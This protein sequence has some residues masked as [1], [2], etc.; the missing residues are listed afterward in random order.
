MKV[1][2]TVVLLVHLVLLFLL[3]GMLLNA[4]VPP[5]VFPFF[6]LLSLGFPILIIGYILIT[7]YWIVYWKKR[8]LFFLVAGFL[9]L[10]PTKRWVNLSSTPTEKSNLKI[11]TFN[12]KGGQMGIDKIEEYIKQ[13]NA[14]IVLLQ[15]DGGN[16]FNFNNLKKGEHIPVVSLYTKLKILDHKNILTGNF[17]D[18]NAYSDYTDVEVEGKPIRI[19]NMYLQPFKFEK[20]KV[21]L[22]GNSEE[23]E[24]KLKYVIKKLIPTFK[25]HQEQVAIIRKAIEDSPYPVIVT[26]DFNS[27]PNSY[28]YYHIGDGL[29]DSFFEVGNG[30][31]T[32]FHDYKF[33]LR[34]DFIF[35]SPSIL[36]IHH[37]VDRST[38][39]SD[40]FPTS[41]TFYVK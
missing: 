1:F 29:L 33:P 20:S 27:V 14:D 25:I 22:N 15:E 39:L 2:R 3:L 10:N 13:Q 24:A 5:K 28:E 40:H 37:H 7:L 17:E 23:D 31:G 9:F 36:P 35:S 26:G 34:I 30:F 11:V 32:S 21:K 16:R 41:A 8:A 12:V 18:I 38:K 19:I 4:Y 6:N